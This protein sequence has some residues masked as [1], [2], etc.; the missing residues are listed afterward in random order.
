MFNQE[1]FSIENFLN[2][3]FFVLKPS[4]MLARYAQAISASISAA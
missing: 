4:Q 2:E 3:K 1:T